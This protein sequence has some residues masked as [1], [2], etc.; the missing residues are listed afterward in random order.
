[1]LQGD[2]VTT[3]GTFLVPVEGKEEDSSLL[4]LLLVSS[5]LTVTLRMSVDNPGTRSIQIVDCAL[6]CVAPYRGQMEERRVMK[7]VGEL[8][9]PSLP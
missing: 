3:G 6:F 5:V 7:G 8:R 9:P 4:C 2:G 1:M